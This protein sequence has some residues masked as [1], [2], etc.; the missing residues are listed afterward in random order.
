M[1][2]L[3]D[4][5]G[6]VGV[7]LTLASM[8]Y[9]MHQFPSSTVKSVLLQGP[10]G[11]GKTS[12]ATLLAAGANCAKS[13]NGPCGECA[14]CAAVYENRHPGY[15]TYYAPDLSPE[16]F[17]RLAGWGMGLA[18]MWRV[19]VFEDVDRLSLEQV[20]ALSRLMDYRL[21]ST[22][23]VM[24][25]HT[26][27][28]EAL[29][30]HA[31]A[32][33]TENLNAEQARALADT[34]SAR[35]EPVPTEYLESAGGVPRA[36]I[37]AATLWSNGGVSEPRADHTVAMLRGALMGEISAGLVAVEDHLAAGGTYEEA[38]TGWVRGATAILSGKV[39][40]EIPAE[41]VELADWLT[42]P[43]AMAILRLVNEK[44]G[45]SF[46]HDQ[47]T[48]LRGLFALLCHAVDPSAFEVISETKSESE[49]MPTHVSEP[50]PS[51]EDLG[52][53]FFGSK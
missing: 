17:S 40:G 7:T 52:S 15:V 32:L 18:T 11:T 34:V 9:T 27:P 21:P 29:L 36:V 30:S 53:E 26:Y 13:V 6:N 28:D 47:S 5:Y 19:M 44:G 45:L 3:T 37:A 23:V 31:V 4:V 8:C 10:Y 22:L 1:K 25:S 35:E 49:S 39:T 2:R 41:Y 24:T 51:I 43:R 33:T 46:V 16:D 12:M 20:H 48:R 38:V 42:A 14:T 50:E